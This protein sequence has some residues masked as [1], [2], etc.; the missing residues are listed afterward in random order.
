LCTLA[1]TPCPTRCV[2]LSTVPLVITFTDHSSQP[3]QRLNLSLT[4][5]VQLYAP[6][7]IIGIKIIVAIKSEKSLRCI[8]GS[9]F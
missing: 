4:I 5:P 8:D 3:D 7:K 9:Y 2:G 1:L 6:I